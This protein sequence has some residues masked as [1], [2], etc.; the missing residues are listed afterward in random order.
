MPPNCFSQL[1]R[2]RQGLP[3]RFSPTLDQLIHQRPDLF[4]EGWP[5]VPNHIDLLENNIH[6]DIATGKIV[7][8]CDWRGAEV[9]SF[10]MS[11]GGGGRDHAWGFDDEWKLL[12]CWSP[13][14]CRRR[15][16]PHQAAVAAEANPGAFRKKSFGMRFG[17]STSLT[18]FPA[19]VGPLGPPPQRALLLAHPL[20]LNSS[21]ASGSDSAWVPQIKLCLG[22]VAW[23][24]GQLALIL[25]LAK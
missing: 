2:L 11:L 4:T 19:P 6:V 13:S 18:S 12:A 25:R 23:G 21:P 14:T 10:G 16:R 15:A 22:C 17:W 9:S 7:G 20:W 24:C 1:Q 8:I 5:L 3:E